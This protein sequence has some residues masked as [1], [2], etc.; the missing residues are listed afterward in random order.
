MKGKTNIGATFKEESKEVV[1]HFDK[2]ENDSDDF[3]AAF[4]T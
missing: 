3:Q 4:Q 1:E 2:N